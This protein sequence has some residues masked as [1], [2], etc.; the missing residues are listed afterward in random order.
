MRALGGPVFGLR[1]LA[2]ILVGAALLLPL[3]PAS[4]RAD[5]KPNL[6]QGLALE[7]Y[8]AVSYQD[9][10]KPAKGLA[11]FSCTLKG[12]TWRFA[13]AAHLAA[14]QKDPARWEPAFGGWCAYAMSRG[15]LVEVDPLDFKVVKGRL[16]LFYRSLFVDTLAKWNP[17]EADLLPKADASW[18]RLNQA[19]GR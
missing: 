15:E 7:G 18:A 2:G 9:G 3:A 11:Q 14:F 4:L 13:T 19:L 16:L 17:Q 6:D 1:A 12:A 8:D 10:G 5:V